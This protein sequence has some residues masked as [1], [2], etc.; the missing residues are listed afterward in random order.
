M[1]TYR[2]HLKIANLTLDGYFNYGN[3]LQR[4]A[5]CNLLMGLGAE[6]ESLWFSPQAGFLPYLQSHYPWMKESWDW[7]TWVKL[8]INWKGATHK[9]FSGE[10]AWEAAR[11]AVIK[12]FVDR[13]IP[14][15]YDVDFAKVADEYDY[16]VTGSDQVWN[17]YFADLEKLFIKFA[18]GEKRIAYAASISCPEILVPYS[19]CGD[20]TGRCRLC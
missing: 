8:G 6:V 12:S 3:V 5:V 4:Y 15:R 2:E 11:N 17:P 18:P 16:F 14:M 19:F 9:M 1:K 10:N 20:G 13:Y 7:K